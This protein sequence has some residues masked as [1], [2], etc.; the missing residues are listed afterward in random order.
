ME[1]IFL[2]NILKLRYTSKREVQMIVNWFFKT[3]N[4]QM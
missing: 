3:T 2:L 4:L 1:K